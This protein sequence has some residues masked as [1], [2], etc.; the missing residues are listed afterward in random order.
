MKVLESTKENI[1]SLT[2]D[3]FLRRSREEEGRVWDLGAKEKIMS[4]YGSILVG[5]AVVNLGL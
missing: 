3:P 2:E 4:L 5:A 1:T